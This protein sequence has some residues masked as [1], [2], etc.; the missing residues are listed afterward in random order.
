MQLE[1]AK[2]TSS[3]NRHATKWSEYI[4]NAEKIW[5]FEYRK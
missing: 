5:N 4:V 1:F 3:D 2:E